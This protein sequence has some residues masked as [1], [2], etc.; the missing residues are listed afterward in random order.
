[1]PT[2]PEPADAAPPAPPQDVETQP[3]QSSAAPQDAYLRSKEAEPAPPQGSTAGDAQDVVHGESESESDSSG[4]EL[5][6]EEDRPE[7]KEGGGEEDTS[8]IRRK[9]YKSRAERQA[10]KGCKPGNQGK[11]HGEALAYL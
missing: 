4:S 10:R 6:D 9:R 8:P 11:F 1:M 5:S 2:D 7:G 3:R